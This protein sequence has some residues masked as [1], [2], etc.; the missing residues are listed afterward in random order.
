[1]KKIITLTVFIFIFLVQ[2][3]FAGEEVI[4]K[5]LLGLD[6]YMKTFSD[7]Q[8]LISP[9]GAR[10]DRKYFKVVENEIRSQIAPL[11]ED[12][13]RI[14]TAL[15]WAL[16]S[17]YSPAVVQIRPAE[18]NKILPANNPKQADLILGGN[19]F[20]E[21]QI[22][23]FLGDTKAVGRYEGM[24][25][26][27]TDRKNVTRAEIEKYYRDGIRGFVAEIVNEEFN[28]IS[29]MIDNTKTR[30]SYNAVLTRNPKTGE[31]KLNYESRTSNIDKEL[32]A[33]TLEALLSAMSKSNDFDKNSINQV[34]AQAGL[35]PAVVYADWQKKGV[36]GGVD[37]LALITEAVTNFYLNPNDNT[38]LTMY[39]IRLRYFALVDIN[40]DTFAEIAFQ[41]H[42]RLISNLS[43]ELLSKFRAESRFSVYSATKI[44]NDPRYDIFSTRY[45]VGGK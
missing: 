36:A 8:P 33:K 32:S 17:Y 45:S 6:G 37:A 1:M 26:F 38:Y 30:I 23:R 15:E 29:F 24:L 13:N 20:K 31:Y 19:V 44:P 39:G 34:R 41:A 10:I 7:N 40:K 4:S 9:N 21:M 14:D 18:A 16:A 27:I 28:K 5:R 3:A 25:N 22:L 2:N 35:I 42:N 12:P 43:P 11:E